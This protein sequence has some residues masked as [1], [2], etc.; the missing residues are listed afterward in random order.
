MSQKY[1]ALTLDQAKEVLV[2]WVHIYHSAYHSGICRVPLAKY[3]ESTTFYRP[4]IDEDYAEFICRI[5]YFRKISNGQIQYDNQF[6]Y[7]HALRTLELKGSRDI[8]IYVNESDLSK[9]CVKTSEKGE[10][11]E[12]S[13]DLDY[14]FNLTLDDHHEAQQIKRYLK[15]QDLKNYPYSDNVLARIAL[16]QLIIGFKKQNKL[17]EENSLIIKTH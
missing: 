9:I 10:M 11:I 6:Y 12:A 15:E 2:R 7:S 8:T 3:K 17:I 13:T 16:N 5:P 4:M 14:T 1:A